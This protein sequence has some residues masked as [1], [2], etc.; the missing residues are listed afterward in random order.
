M[1]KPVYTLTDTIVSRLSEIA[2]IKSVVERSALLPAREVF[3]RRAAVIKMAHTSTSI[4]GNQLQ[5]YEVAKLVEGKKV[6][7]EPDQVKEVEN[8]LVALRRMDGLADAKDSF[9]ASD[10]LDIHKVVVEGLVDREKAGVWRKGPVYIVN[11]LGKGREELAYTPPKSGEVPGLIEDLLSWL[12]ANSQIHPVI[13][14]GLFHYQFETIHPFPDGN[15]RTGRLMS[16]LHLYQSGWDF[17]KVLVLEDYYNRNRKNY[18]TALQTGDTYTARQGVDL[19]DWLE[20]Y[21]EGFLDEAVRVK[22]RV[23]N[24][25]VVGDRALTANVLDNEELKIVDFVITMGRI[26]SSDVVDILRVPKRTAQGRLK[27]LE[28]MKVLQK[29]S[30]GPSTFYTLAPM[31]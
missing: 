25:A 12:K 16:L 27:R 17:K 9:N 23:T 30:A 15:G 5:E 3:L 8:Y 4:E 14:S 10:I 6:I 22:D 13:R 1:F 2:G 21:V 18:Y 20:Y 26:T 19:T 31:E 29:Q 11:V 28:D 7:A 24:V